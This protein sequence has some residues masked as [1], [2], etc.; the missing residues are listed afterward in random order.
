MS[1]IANNTPPL[2][3]FSVVA[4]NRVDQEFRQWLQQCGFWSDS[5]E[6][7]F[8]FL[9]RS[10][11]LPAPITDKQ[12]RLL[13]QVIEDALNGINIAERYPAFFRDL[14]HSATLRREFISVAKQINTPA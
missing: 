5:T 4:L 1:T 11:Q 8:L 12:E 9:A 2:R 3:S 10:E 7:L 13:G 6:R 14:L